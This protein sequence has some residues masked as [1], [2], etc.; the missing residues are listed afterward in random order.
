MLVHVAIALVALLA[1][2]GL[3]VDYGILWLARRQAQNSADAGAH[4]RRGVAGVRR[5]RRLRTRRDNRR[6]SA[7]MQN[8]V[9]GET[10]DI[11]DA[12][13]TFPHLPA[14]LAWGGRP[15][16]AFASTSFATSG[17]T[18][19]RSR[20][21]SAACSASPTKASRPPRPRKCCTA[22][23][24]VELRAALGDCRQVM[25]RTTS[26]RT[27][28]GWHDP[29]DTFDRYDKDGIRVARTRAIPNDP[30]DGYRQHRARRDSLPTV[31]PQ[32]ARDPR[33]TASSTRAATTA[34]QFDAEA[35]DT[36]RTR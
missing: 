11:T 35:G 4:G 28:Q 16:P 26:D 1:F 10:P 27:R 17:R 5:L 31:E 20:R 18:A 22:N 6:S 13:V 32:S 7:A 23:V 14:R 29:T 33:A 21:S 15:P 34:W 12:D 36:A 24:D 30:T 3:V 19:S 9:W 25:R 8:M 2:S